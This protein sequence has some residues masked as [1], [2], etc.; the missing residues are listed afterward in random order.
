[1]FKNETARNV[2]WFDFDVCQEKDRTNIP[3]NAATCAKQ[4]NMDWQSFSACFT[5]NTG[6]SLMSASIK[7]TKAA[8][9][10]VCCSSFPFTYI[11][12]QSDITY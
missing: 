8:G 2:T 1:M 9:I 3:A 10:G 4:L 7:R 6:T 11:H 5:G 12:L